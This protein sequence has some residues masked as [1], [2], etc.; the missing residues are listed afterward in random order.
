MTNFFVVYN[1]HLTSGGERK[2]KKNDRN[3]TPELLEG[4]VSGK[5]VKV[6]AG[7]VAEAQAFVR[8][9]FGGSST[10]VV[11]VTEAQWKES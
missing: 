5:V 11:A 4:P 6:S 2:G 10:T 9:E 1:Q 8:Q 7:S 3:T